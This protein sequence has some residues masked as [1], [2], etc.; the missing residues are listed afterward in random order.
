MRRL[1]YAI[2]VLVVGA[3]AGYLFTYLYRWE[4]QRALLAGL[5]LV[6]AELALVA[7]VVLERLGRLEGHLHRSRP[8]RPSPGRDQ[9]EGRRLQQGAPPPRLRFAWLERDP[10]AL[11]VFIPVLLG[12][13]ML[14]SA[15]AW[16][17][18]W[19]AHRT[20]RPAAERGLAGQLASLAPPLGSPLE[21]D[22]RPTLPP[23]RP[24]RRAG[25]LLAVALA[26]AL[27]A[28]GLARLT[29]NR[30]DPPQ[31][32][33]A[34]TLVLQVAHRQDLQRAGTLAASVWQRCVTTI[35]GAGATATGLLALDHGRYAVLLRPAPGPIA[36][37]RLRGCLQDAT[38]DRVQ[39]QAVTV[40]GVEQPAA[41]A[42]SLPS[43]A[44]GAAPG[45]HR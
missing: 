26:A 43:A 39:L 17:L 30:P 5:L 14:V 21:G 40:T 41:T 18:E 28:G 9:A 24:W 8:D 42:P 6:A 15:L 20:A 25:W 33:Q 36:T 11:A 45:A 16:L 23:R 31:P 3:C 13:G 19:A 44:T 7:G 22:T 2:G 27:L 4:W 29:Q 37:R 34:A 32:A 12:A 35:L 10:D 38:T 1:A